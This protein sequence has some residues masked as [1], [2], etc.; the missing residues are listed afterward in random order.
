[1]PGDTVESANGQ[2][3]ELL[4]R[5]RREV[6]VVVAASRAAVDDLYRDGLALVYTRHELNGLRGVDVGVLLTVRG[7]VL[8]ANTPA[9]KALVIVRGKASEELEETY[10]V[11]WYRLELT[12]T[13][14]WLLLFVQP[15][16]P[17]PG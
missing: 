8:A 6:Q 13:T 4:E 15:Q 14:S 3:S 17:R 1:M 10:G 5:S 16:A 12:A 2:R 9:H 7:E 11:L